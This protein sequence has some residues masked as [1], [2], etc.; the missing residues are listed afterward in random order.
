[1]DL[2][3]GILFVLIAFA[4]GN[5]IAIGISEERA[6]AKEQDEENMR[7]LRREER[8]KKLFGRS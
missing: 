5:Y 1:M 8:V 7:R 4:F 3:T 2:Q 6:K